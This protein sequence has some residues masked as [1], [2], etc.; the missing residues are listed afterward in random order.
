MARVSRP[1]AMTA[2]VF[3]PGDDVSVLHGCP[4]RDKLGHDQP[5]EAGAPRNLLHA[6]HVPLQV[7]P[8]VCV[9]MCVFVFF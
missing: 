3:Y 2:V 9:C 8:C 1:L 6:V 5:H 7:Q 4:R